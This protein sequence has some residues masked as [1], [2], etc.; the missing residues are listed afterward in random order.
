MEPV[1]KHGVIS[2]QGCPGGPSLSL[3]FPGWI[4]RFD[5]AESRTPLV[6]GAGRPR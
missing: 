6:V 4:E 2:G 1:R 5:G 3:R